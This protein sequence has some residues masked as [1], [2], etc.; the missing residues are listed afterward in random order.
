MIT[1]LQK[2]LLEISMFFYLSCNFCKVVY[3]ENDW[4]VF[5]GKHINGVG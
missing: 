3:T 2:M 4:R 1:L 5:N